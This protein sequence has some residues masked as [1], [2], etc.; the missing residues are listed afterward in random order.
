[1][2]I[3]KEG[4]QG[5]LENI[6]ELN[7]SNENHILAYTVQGIETRLGT[8]ENMSTKLENLNKILE[9]VINK[10]IMGNSVEYI[11]LRLSG[12]PVRKKK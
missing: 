11:D 9:D 2:A 8:L 5:F 3:L 6:V 7:I 4:K 10:E 1:M 12:P